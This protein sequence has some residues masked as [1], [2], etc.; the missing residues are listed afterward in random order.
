MSDEPDLRLIRAATSLSS[1][2]PAGALASVGLFFGFWPLY[3]VA[4]IWY[5]VTVSHSLVEP[6]DTTRVIE[7]P[8]APVREIAP[9]SV[10]FTNIEVVGLQ[11]DANREQR[12]LEKAIEDSLLP[13][14]ELHAELIGMREDLLV[15]CGQAERLSGYIA[16]ISTD[17]LV[18][19]RT[20]IL[21][22]RSQ[23]VSAELVGALDRAV[24]AIDD[25]LSMAAAMSEQ[26]D[27]LV[28]DA[29]GIILNL[30]SIRAEVIRI[31]VS[32]DDGAGARVI[33]RIGAARQD[34]R[35][36]RALISKQED[37]AE[38]RPGAPASEPTEIVGTD[39]SAPGDTAREGDV[40]EA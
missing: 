24:Q 8:Q 39:A 31:G 7:A 2:L 1:V 19:R 18:R 28:A 11:V 4:T 6:E 40:A 17:A 20:E 25:Q 37:D 14:P 33:E 16:T 32:A 9:Q 10:A 23:A 26:Y 13:L 29:T 34:M 3:V 21:E 38:I 35:E 15:V 22:R 5:V 27:R 36:L 30:G 12:L